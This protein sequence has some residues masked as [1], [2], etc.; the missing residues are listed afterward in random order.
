M[1]ALAEDEKGKLE[2]LEE[3]VYHGNPFRSDGSLV[4]YDFGWDILEICKNCGFSDVNMVAYFS[5]RFG[6][7][8][9]H[10]PLFMFTA[11]RK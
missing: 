10:A 4:F 6:H 1:A 9:H 5:K 7:L 8:N 3:A 11:I 2:P